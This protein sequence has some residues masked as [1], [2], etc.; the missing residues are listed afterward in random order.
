MSKLSQRQER[1]EID[2]NNMSHNEVK[3]PLDVSYCNLSLPF[4]FSTQGKNGKLCNS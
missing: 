2:N 4:I 1:M 3:L